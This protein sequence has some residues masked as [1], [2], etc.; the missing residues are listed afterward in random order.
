MD[1]RPRVE[2]SD[3]VASVVANYRA[4]GLTNNDIVNGCNDPARLCEQPL[5]TPEPLSLRGSWFTWSKRRHVTLLTPTSFASRSTD[6]PV[7]R[8]CTEHA[9]QIAAGTVGGFGATGSVD[10]CPMTPLGT[11][12]VHELYAG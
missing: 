4:A 11:A 12:R 10:N 6:R 5:T 9:P 3:S 2:P 7:G 1:I 8:P